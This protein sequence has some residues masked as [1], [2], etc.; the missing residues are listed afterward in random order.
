VFTAEDDGRSI[1][2]SRSDL[3]ELRETLR[4]RGII[5]FIERKT[6]AAERTRSSLSAG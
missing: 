5:L 6:T 4:Q 1:T 3:L 2:C